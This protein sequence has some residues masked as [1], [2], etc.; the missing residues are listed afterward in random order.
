MRPDSTEPVNAGTFRWLKRLA[1]RRTAGQAGASQRN[2]NAGTSCAAGASFPK[3]RRLIA[4]DGWRGFHE[5]NCFSNSLISL[6]TDSFHCFS[7]LLDAVTIS[8]SDRIR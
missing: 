2:L 8:A 3:S 4:A 1:V 5:R 6:I 7:D